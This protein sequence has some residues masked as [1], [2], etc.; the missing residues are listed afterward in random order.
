MSP[1]LTLRSI[2]AWTVDDLRTHFHVLTY[3]R[4]AYKIL[5]LGESLE[6]RAGFD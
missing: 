1:A 3:G 5:P 4:G 6:A 2:L